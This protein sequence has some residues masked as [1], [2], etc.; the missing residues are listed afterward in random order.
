[1]SVTKKVSL[2]YSDKSS[3][4]KKKSNLHYTRRTTTKR[5][6]S[7]GAYLSPRLRAWATQLRKNVATV[8]GRW[9][10]CADLIGPGIESQTYR[11]DSVRLATELTRFSE[12]YVLFC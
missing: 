6:T 1:M 2:L 12:N 7:G 9:R 5:V 4:K 8:A 3:K 11:S 10:H